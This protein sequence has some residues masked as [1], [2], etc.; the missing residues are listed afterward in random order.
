MLV[1]LK[2]FVRCH[3][4]PG[5]SKIPNSR[6]FLNIRSSYTTKRWWSW[7]DF[8]CLCVTFPCFILIL[9]AQSSGTV[10]LNP[11][12]LYLI[13]PRIPLKGHMMNDGI[14]NPSKQRRERP[15]WDITSEDWAAD[16]QL[17]YLPISPHYERWKWFSS[18]ILWRHFFGT[19][20]KGKRLL[21][22]FCLLLSKSYCSLI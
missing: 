14:I 6:Y 1:F 17:I 20:F 19:D 16:S 15:G 13:L 22:L 11:Q 21:S 10:V 8:L 9:W 3:T 12:W 4:V 2:R 5:K 7:L 18:N